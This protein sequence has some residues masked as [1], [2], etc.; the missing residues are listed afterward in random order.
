MHLLT[1]GNPNCLGIRRQPAFMP[2]CST[3]N[4]AVRLQDL[5]AVTPPWKT[6]ALSQFLWRVH[7]PERAPN[8]EVV[9]DLQPTGQEEGQTE[10]RNAERPTSERRR[11]RRRNGTRDVGNPRRGR[12]LLRIDDRPRIA[13]PGRHIHL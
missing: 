13:L 1:V 12:A 6:H 7:A 9:S 5:A 8:K 10:R 11:D 4:L 3:G 2:P